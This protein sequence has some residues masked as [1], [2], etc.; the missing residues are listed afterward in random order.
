M[1]PWVPRTSPLS[2]TAA[3]PRGRGLGPARRRTIKLR[4]P[5][6][7]PPSRASIARTANFLYGAAQAGTARGSSERRCGRDEDKLC[8]VEGCGEKHVCRTLSL[9][10][11]RGRGAAAAAEISI[12]RVVRS[13]FC[14]EHTCRGGGAGRDGRFCKCPKFPGPDRLCGCCAER[15]GEGRGE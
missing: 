10:P 5:P 7:P 6:P 2:T 11:S 12:P 3:A 13:L 9:G 8:R 14:Q 4:P 15:E 1:A